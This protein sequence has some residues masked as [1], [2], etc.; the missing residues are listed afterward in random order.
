MKSEIAEKSQKDQEEVA[1][2]PKP[3]GQQ[4]QPWSGDEIRLFIHE[5]ELLG[6]L[7]A[8]KNIKTAKAIAQRLKT[9]GILRSRKQCL[10]LLENLQEMYWTIHR[11][12]QRP[13]SQ[14]LPCPFGEALNRLLGP[15]RQHPVSGLPAIAPLGFVPSVVSKLPTGPSPPAIPNP[16]TAPSPLMAPGLPNAPSS[17]TDCSLDGPQPLMVTRPLA[18]PAPQ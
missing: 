1:A 7:Q 10:I 2:A 12:N 13:R 18:V 3:L 17:L 15:K 5:W 11:A 14:P 4:A 16:L 6:N 8:K 9:K